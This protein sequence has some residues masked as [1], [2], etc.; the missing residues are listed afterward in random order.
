VPVSGSGELRLVY[1]PTTSRVAVAGFAG[2][3]LWW[4]VDD[5]LTGDA[6]RMVVAAPVLLAIGIALW[7]IFWRPAVIV[8]NAGVSLL[9]IVRDVDVP[10]SLLELVETRYALTLHVGER[11][12]RSWAAGAPGRPLPGR[13]AVSRMP[14]EKTVAREHDVTG[15]AE[16]IRS[17]RSLRGDSGAAAFMVEQRWQQ[18]RN[19][20]RG[21]AAEADPAA[22]DQRVRVTW[23]WQ[24]PAA[25]ALL[26]LT[27]TIAAALT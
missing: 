12:Y 15:E 13:S 16:A 22:A 2:F 17:S 1:R 9:N 10:W 7:G 6:G 4:I 20:R 3:A 26:L 18:H 14:E 19:L 25:T 23:A 21:S 5:L 27:A 24:W 8:D 11:R